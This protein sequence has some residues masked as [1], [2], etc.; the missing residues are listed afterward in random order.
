MKPETV[1]VAG[2]NGYVGK[3]VACAFLRAGWVTFGLIRFTEVQR[4]TGI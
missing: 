1:L 3:A 4:I 2:A